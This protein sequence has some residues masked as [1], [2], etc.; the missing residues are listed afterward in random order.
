M[1]ADLE[2][3]ERVQEF[4]LQAA[5]YF[6]SLSLLLFLRAEPAP[7]RPGGHTPEPS[8]GPLSVSLSLSRFRFL[9]VRALGKVCLPLTQLSAAL[10]LALSLFRFASLRGGG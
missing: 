4:P 2:A 8:H 7:C 1:S 5:T 6:L 3:K 10:R 9:F